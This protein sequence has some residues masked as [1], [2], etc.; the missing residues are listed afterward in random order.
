MKIG[1][2]KRI[3]D[4]RRISNDPKQNE[5]RRPGYRPKKDETKTMQKTPN[6]A[7]TTHHF[8]Q[9]D[10]LLPVEKLA[11]GVPFR[12]IVLVLVNYLK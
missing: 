10:I 11:T 2:Q 9:R 5:V 8:P 1:V 7:R 6:I 3:R 4:V 12:N